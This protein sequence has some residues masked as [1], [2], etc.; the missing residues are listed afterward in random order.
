MAK[1]SCFTLSPVGMLVVS[2]LVEF[3]IFLDKGALA[4]VVLQLESHSGL[5]LSS[6]EAGTLGSLGI[7]GYILSCPVNANFSQ[8]IHPEYLIS[9]GLAI[10]S[11]SI[12]MSAFSPNFIML[13]SLR[14]LTGISVGAWGCLIPPMIIDSAP[15]EKG[16]FG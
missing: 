10:W 7:L 2:T 15:H 11:G 8:F 16:L 3:V 4:S 9:L 12:F 5:N 1:L 13:A 14:F 6:F